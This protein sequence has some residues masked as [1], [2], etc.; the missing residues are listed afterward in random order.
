MPTKEILQVVLIPIITIVLTI[1]WDSVSKRLIR[2][3]AKDK[4]ISQSIKDSFEKERDLIYFFRFHTVG[5]LT[6]RE[7]MKAIDNL[8]YKL[9]SPGFVFTI[10]KL[11]KLRIK[12]LK[13]ITNFWK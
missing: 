2:N 7:Y 8:K 4:E 10:K 1:V 12:L 11:E 13:K 3:I 9:E 5:D 6:H